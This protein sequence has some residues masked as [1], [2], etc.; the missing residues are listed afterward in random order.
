MADFFLFL[1]THLW[2]T[3]IWA[4]VLGVVLGSFL[5]VVILRWPVQLEQGWLAEARDILGLEAVVVPAEAAPGIHEHSRCPHCHTPIRWFDNVPLLSYLW[6]RGRCRTCQAPISAQYP[7]V[8]AIAGIGVLWALLHWGVTWTALMGSGLW[9]V[10]L[11][12]AMIDLRTMLL[13]DPLVY[14]LLWAGLLGSAMGIPGLPSLPQAV[15]G[16]AVGYVSL[17][18]FYWLFKLVRGKEGL[19]YGDFK[20]LAALGAW[21]GGWNLIPI[22]V[23]ATAAGLVG[24]LLVWLARRDATAPLPFGPSLAVGGWLTFLYPHWLTPILLA[25]QHLHGG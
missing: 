11:T 22:I 9:L 7:L 16:A 17:W 20:L 19:G 15:V 3:L 23:L 6:L 5:N 12:L 21:C 24:A 4:G 1:Q 2:F 18:S 10:L 25:L 8:E 14:V 13:P